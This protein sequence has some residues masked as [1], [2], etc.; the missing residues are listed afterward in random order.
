MTN[1]MPTPGNGRFS[2]PDDIGRLGAA[3]LAEAIRDRTYSVAEVVKSVLSR[4][5]KVNSHVN[6][7]V[8]LRDREELLREADDADRRL[9]AGE[10]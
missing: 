1:T 3:D 8:S 2:P 10:G 7:I 9:A 5:D 6:A 4:I